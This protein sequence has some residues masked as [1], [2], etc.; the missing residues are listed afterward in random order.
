M[1]APRKSK[2]QK[3]QKGRTRGIARRGCSL[4]FGSFGLQSMG[5]KWITARQIEAARLAISKLIKGHG[6]VWIRI[7]P[8]KPIT[9]KGVEVGMGGGKG[10][11]IGHV[12]PIRPGKI[13]FE[14]EGVNE[15]SA[16]DAFRKAGEKLPIRT[17]FIK[18]GI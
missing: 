13:I 14:I 12:C 16:R 5:A 15:E 11:V 10:R 3:M 17:R 7:F 6:K 1:L 4:A 8:H 2:Y 9:T 18:K